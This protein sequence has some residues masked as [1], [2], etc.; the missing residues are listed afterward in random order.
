MLGGCRRYLTHPLKQLSCAVDKFDALDYTDCMKW[1]RLE[2]AILAAFEKLP[3]RTR[4]TTP[5][6]RL[7]ALIGI[8]LGLVV[9]VLGVS[10]PAVELVADWTGSMV[11][12]TTGFVFLVLSNALLIIA[13]IVVF[14]GGMNFGG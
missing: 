1:T 3:N 12:A 7:F 13:M 5:R 4:T 14:I 9:V 10:G 6:E 2:L 11:L 8:R